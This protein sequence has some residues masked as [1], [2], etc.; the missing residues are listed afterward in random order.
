MATN[1]IYTQFILQQQYYMT[2]Q[3]EFFEHLILDNNWDQRT[4][5]LG[6]EIKILKMQIHL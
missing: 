3:Q 1:D 5:Q 4:K 6:D 2:Q